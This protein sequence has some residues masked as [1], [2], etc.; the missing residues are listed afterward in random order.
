MAK[1]KFSTRAIIEIAGK[2]KEHIEETMKLVVKKLKHEQGIKVLKSKVH[3]AEEHGE[4]F[5][6]F[7]ELE[8]EHDSLESITYF[9]FE[10]LPSSLEMVE[11]ESLKV[12]M[13]TFSEVFNDLLGKLH[14]MDNKLKN[15]AAA[16]IILDK[17]SNNLLKVL[18]TLALK[19]GAKSVEQLSNYCMIIPVQ[20]KP[21]L[22][23]YVQEKIINKEGDKYSL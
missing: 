15:M 5:S 10:Y 1:Q 2:P 6:T 14:S 22:E 12:E 8:L 18:V 23:R 20:L 4:V 7:A 13:Q 17:N 21:F 3:D 9:C 16:N 11:P 19:D